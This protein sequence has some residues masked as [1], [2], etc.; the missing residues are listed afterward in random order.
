MRLVR[1]DCFV[2]TG[3]ALCKS[4]VSNILLWHISSNELVHMLSNSSGGRKQQITHRSKQN[5]AGFSARGFRPS[6]P[7]ARTHERSTRVPL[8]LQR[9][10]QR[11]QNKHICLESKRR[12]VLD[13][14]H[15]DLIHFVLCQ[16]TLC[17]CIWAS[18]FFRIKKTLCDSVR[19][20]KNQPQPCCKPCHPV[21]ILA[22]LSCPPCSIFRRRERWIHTSPALIISS[23]NEELL[24]PCG[25][26]DCREPKA[27]F[28]LTF[29]VCTHVPVQ[30]G[31]TLG[32]VISMETP[33]SSLPQLTCSCIVIYV[34]LV[35]RL[36]SWF[37]PVE[38]LVQGFVL[39]MSVAG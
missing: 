28:V 35:P 18:A 3:N 17:N 32:P 20:A 26:F 11:P 34:A 16:V 6:C 33:A 23:I 10:L 14:F 29:G 13:C 1:N 22:K 19:Q 39:E 2:I 8:V 5:E 36:L 27:S 38:L 30:Y 7:G 31:R 15:S 25:A 12:G 21:H 37:V 9:D 24:H 4:L